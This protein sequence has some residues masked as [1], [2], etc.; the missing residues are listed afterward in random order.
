MSVRAPFMEAPRRLNKEGSTLSLNALTRASIDEAGAAHRTPQKVCTMW[1]ETAL[2]NEPFAGG[3]PVNLTQPDLLRSWPDKGR[4]TNAR[5]R[6]SL[7]DESTI[8]CL[9]AEP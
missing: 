9:Q 6:A 2:A 7:K 8:C 3:G 1:E 5:S 4:S